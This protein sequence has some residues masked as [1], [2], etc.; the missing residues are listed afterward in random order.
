MQNRNLLHPSAGASRLLLAAVVAALALAG[1]AGSARAAFAIDVG[2]VILAPNQANQV[3]Q[4]QFTGSGVADT[5]EFV[6]EVGDGSGGPRIT[7]IDL[8]TGTFAGTGTQADVVTEPWAQLKTV[9]LASTSISAGL[10]ATVTFDT[11]GLSG[12]SS[13]PLLLTGVYVAGSEVLRTRFISEGSAVPTTVTNGTISIAVP[14]PASIGL[15]GVGAL[16][17]LRRRRR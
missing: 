13:Q 9:D 6:I 15:L 14:E 2:D 1:A 8:K 12:P 7:A 16:A 5:L 4:F 17:L 3:R 10:L 11:T